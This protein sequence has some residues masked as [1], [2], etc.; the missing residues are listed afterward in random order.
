MSRLVAPISMKTMAFTVSAKM[1]SERQGA[2][3]GF[4]AA[5]ERLAD[6]FFGLYDI[7]AN[8]A[9]GELGAFGYAGRA[10]GVLQKRRCL[11]M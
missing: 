11:P 10:A 8:I 4:F 9:V 6:P 3:G 2:D 1:W 7:G 5:I